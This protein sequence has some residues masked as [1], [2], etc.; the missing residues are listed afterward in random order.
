[1][2]FSCNFPFMQSFEDAR[3]NMAF[4][5]LSSFNEKRARLFGGNNPID[6]LD[7]NK[8]HFTRVYPRGDRITSSNFN[9][10]VRWRFC[11]PAG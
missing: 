5:N 4:Y 6:F 10:Q 9:P 8:V 1:M 3:Q 7:H 11:N 2:S